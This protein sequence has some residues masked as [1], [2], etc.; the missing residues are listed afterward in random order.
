M[1]LCASCS[2]G[3]EGEAST[4]DLGFIS[5]SHP[6]NVEALGVKGCSGFGGRL[7]KKNK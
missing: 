4:D 7:V 5:I 6:W 1:H 3:T 2:G